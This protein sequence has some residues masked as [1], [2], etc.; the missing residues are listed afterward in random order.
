MTA[1]WQ[2][3]GAGA[4]ADG[5]M[6]LAGVTVAGGEVWVRQ[7]TTVGSNPTS[8]STW[9]GLGAAPG[10]V[11]VGRVVMA[12]NHSNR[13]QVFASTV[14]GKV[15]YRSQ[16][17]VGSQTFS[18]WT[19]L[20]F[21]GKLRSLAAVANADGR[22]EVLGVDDAGAV[23]RAAQ[24]SATDTNWGQ[25]TKLPGFGVTTISAAR[26]S[27]GALELVGVDA[28]GNTWRRSQTAVGGTA[29][30]G[31]TP[32]PVKTFGQVSARTANNRVQVVGV[33]TLGRIWQSTQNGVNATSYAPWTQIDGALRP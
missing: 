12:H 1:G 7:E 5:R 15:Y 27:N 18:G 4:N 20:P 6:A 24:T 28:G 19:L 2:S 32:L 8:W 29:W 26:N 21:T 16:L 11:A 23:W 25:F 31:W 22:I 17:A 33:D 13:L 9:A 10:N 30:G 3:V 14:Q